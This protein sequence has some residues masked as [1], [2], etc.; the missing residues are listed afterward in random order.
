MII[1]ILVS[2]NSRLTFQ[3]AAGAHVFVASNPG[4]ARERD[5]LN[6]KSSA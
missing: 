2:E 6:E 1:N 3:S 4:K 5:Y